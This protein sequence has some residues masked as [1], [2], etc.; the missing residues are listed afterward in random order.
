MLVLPHQVEMVLK[1]LPRHLALT[2]QESGC[3][4]ISV[5]QADNEPTR[6]DIYAMFID[7]MSYDY[8]QVRTSASEW[9]VITKE[10]ARY[11]QVSRGADNT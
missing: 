10:A 4:K 1:L 11:Y 6:F 3:V 7:Q 2:E 9:G 8:H 5:V